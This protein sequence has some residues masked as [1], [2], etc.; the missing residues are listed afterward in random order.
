MADDQNRDIDPQETQ[1]WRDALASVLEFEGAERAEFIL[2]QIADQASRLGLTTASATHTPYINTL[3]PDQEAKL[4]VEEV[5]LVEALTNIHRWNAIAMVM[6]AGK[7]DSSLGGHIASYASVAI[8]FEV[9]L[10]YF[11]HAKD[12]VFFQGHSSPGI[13]ARAFLE[14]R[15]SAE[16]IQ[17]FRQEYFKDGVASY[18][19][20]WLMPEFWQFATVSMGF[21]PIMAVYQAQFLKY[22]DN[23]GLQDTQQRKVWA[24]LGD[25]EM[26]EPESIG[27]IRLAGRQKL[28]NLIFIINCNLQRLDGPVYGNGQIAQELEGVFRGANWNVIKTIWGSGWDRLFAKDKQGLLL[29]RIS[30]LVD[31]EYQNYSARGGDYLRDKFF[32]KYPELKELVADMTDEQ[33]KTELID[34]GHDVQKVYAAM[35]AAANHQGSPTVILVKTV[36]G[37]GMG[38]VGE[39]LNV[40]HQT[41]KMPL[42]ILKEFRDRFCLEL[43]DKQIEKL[44]FL[45]PKKTDPRMRFLHEQ[46]KKLGGYLPARAHRQEA[47]IEIPPLKTFQAQ[48]DSTGEREIST[49]MAFVRFLAVLLRD[50]NVKEHVVPIVA[51]ESR[52]FGMEGLF[53]QIGIYAPKGQLYEPEDRQQLMYYREDSKGQLFQQGLTE[54]GALSCWIAAGM[55]YS[56]NNLPMIPFFIYYSMFGFQR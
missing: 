27:C 55:S 15:L 5:K 6:H 14:G 54:E 9:G 34:A 12:L 40:T 13:Y 39:A 49:T 17:A 45:K 48:L 46:R 20:P 28:D 25:G 37:Y 29:K 41:K 26:D 50:K 18:P 10:N 23:R 56:L 24:F 2:K 30:E 43:T 32:G 38:S 44:E 19:H 52:T 22:L 7:H 4:P 51:D 11:F 3:D 53:R 35:H 31:G 42:D 33:L 21:S 47:A 8:V 36:K 1:E 16:Q